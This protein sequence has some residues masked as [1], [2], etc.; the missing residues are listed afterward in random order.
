LYDIF[1]NFENFVKFTNIFK[2]NFKHRIIH[3]FSIHGA[4]YK[5]VKLKALGE[6]KTPPRQLIPWYKIPLKVPAGIQ[7][8][9]KIERFVL[10]MTHPIRQK[11][12]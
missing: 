9:T 11:I 6:R 3:E 5:C 12:S 1:T 7:N 2:T 8:N 10:P 4:G